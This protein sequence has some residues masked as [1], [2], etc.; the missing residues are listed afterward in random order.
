ME[1]AITGITGR[2]GGAV[3]RN[4]LTAGHSVR[5]VLRD[6]KKASRWADQRCRVAV[7]DL[8]DA[9]ALSAA[10]MGCDGVFVLLPPN[11]DPSPGFP[12]VR[13]ILAALKAALLAARP[14]RV[15]CIS[16]IGA[17]AATEN[18]LTSL[19]IMEQMLTE[20][21]APIA[22]L[23]PAWFMENCSWD[24]TP[25]RQSG[26]IS[27]FLQPLARAIPMV[28]TTDVASVAARLLNETWSGRRVVEL[29]GP[30]RVSPDDIAATF[31]Q[32]LGKPV[33]AQAVPRE[34]WMDLFL[35]QGMNNPA[36]RVRMLDGF[37]EGW[38]DFE[39]GVRGS[40]KGTTR[41]ETALKALVAAVAETQP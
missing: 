41:L 24:V 35:A 1:H 40:V 23:R 21:G 14:S 13:A 20:V 31:S 8:T 10:F 36:P 22:F 37:N 9:R 28:S 6:E 19:G 32:L 7:A 3:A 26:V 38:I 25:A 27:S 39:S 30:T 33:R 5:A 34:T 15:V 18:L 11:F 4:L 29:E 2:V 16:T 17:Q 12:E